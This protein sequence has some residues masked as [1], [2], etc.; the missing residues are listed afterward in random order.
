MDL[1]TSLKLTWLLKVFIN[2]EELITL[3]FFSLVVKPTTIKLLFSIAI[4]NRTTLRQLD[5]KTPFC[6]VISMKMFIWPRH[7]V[8]FI[9][10]SHHMFVSYI[11]QFIDWNRLPKHGIKNS[12]TF[13]FNSDLRSP[14]LTHHFLCLILVGILFIYWS[15]L[16]I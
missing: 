4:T 6:K 8:S 10:T 14:M 2:T 7:Q 11:K 15:M 16:R 9:K 3:I 1:L 12:D 5:V 13:F